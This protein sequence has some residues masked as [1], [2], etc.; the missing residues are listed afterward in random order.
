MLRKV[1]FL[2]IVLFTVSSLWAQNIPAGLEYEIVGGRSVTIT[3][4]TGDATTLN[5][6]AQIQGLP[7][8]AIGDEAF[9]AFN[10]SLLEVINIPSSVISIGERVFAIWWSGL[11]SITVDSLN[12]AFTSIDGVL[13]D[14]SVRTLITYPNGRAESSY[15]IP[16]SVESIGDVAFE[17][18]YSLRTITIPASIISIY[19]GA[20]SQCNVLSSITVDS[21]NPVYTSLDGVL[22]DKNMQTIIEYPK[23]K[24]S[25]SYSIPS[26]V[27][28]IGDWAFYRC[29][30]LTSIT[31]PSSVRFVGDGAFFDCRSLTGITIPSSVTSI[32]NN[33]FYSC[34]VLTN[35]TVDSRNSV[36][37]SVDGVLFD[38]SMQTIIKYPEGKTA[39]SYSI[40]SSVTS[41]GNGAFESCLNL[42]SITIP[43]SIM[44]I[45]DGTFSSCR[46]LTSATISR[47][48]SVGE[49][50]FPETAQIIYSD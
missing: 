35:I 48:T 29:Q 33:A 6:P 17:N 7:V 19:G 22:F 30:S 41:I 15:T 4:Y 8:T 47:R 23:G 1:S 28:S 16:A 5:I 32:G 20:F 36:Y 10:E 45:G 3:R 31:I 18:N 14:K 25:R 26:S 24:T 40:P 39:G 42:T 43:Y 50:A 27:I 46:G 44:Y 21:R 38:K 13:F 2:L 37:T 11:T 49:G 34:E 12:P 9:S